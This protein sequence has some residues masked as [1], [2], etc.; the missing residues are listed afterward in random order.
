M[1][2]SSFCLCIFSFI[3]LSCSLAA[4]S[5]EAR[6][7]GMRHLVN[8]TTYS[9]SSVAAP[10]VFLGR[11]G[12]SVT[13]RSLA[14]MTGSSDNTVSTSRIFLI[15]R[16]HMLTPRLVAQAVL[17]KTQILA[18]GGAYHFMFKSAHQRDPL[19]PSTATSLSLALLRDALGAEHVSHIMAK[20]ILEQ[21]PGL[22][23]WS[24]NYGLGGYERTSSDVFDYALYSRFKSGE[25]PCLTWQHGVR[26]WWKM[27]NYC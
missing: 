6:H 21:F 17:A 1:V 20:D 25:Q 23:E 7:G 24:S 2:R 9:G 14:S 13:G 10:A 19:K 15:Q 8:S 22:V 16:G 26:T 18:A 27:L 4:C 11:D 3:T 5:E 12:S